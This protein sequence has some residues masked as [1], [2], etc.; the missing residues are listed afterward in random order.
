ML[1]IS[2]YS[3]EG[4]I[5]LI[6]EKI[7]VSS[8]GNVGENLLVGDSCCVLDQ[9]SVGKPGRKKLGEKARAIDFTLVA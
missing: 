4:T 7:F 3:S 2:N 5:F 8:G 9:N 6:E 1:Y